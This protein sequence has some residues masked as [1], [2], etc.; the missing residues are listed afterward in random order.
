MVGLAVRAVD[1]NSVDPCIRPT[2]Q[3]THLIS[4]HFSAARYPRFY[5]A[6]VSPNGVNITQK[7]NPSNDTNFGV[8]RDLM[9]E[10]VDSLKKGERRSRMCDG[11]VTPKAGY[12]ARLQATA[13]GRSSS[14]VVSP[15][16][17]GL[18]RQRQAALARFEFYL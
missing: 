2:A 1:L 4:L 11:A 14:A 9:S 6:R 17:V 13:S 5:C 18:P 16:L 12:L 7:C 3:S 8:A 10:M 15:Q